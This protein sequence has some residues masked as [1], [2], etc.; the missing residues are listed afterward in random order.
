MG[1]GWRWSIRVLWK[2][3]SLASSGGGG[4]GTSAIRM[5]RAACSGGGGGG[6]SAAAMSPLSS[7]ERKSLMLFLLNSFK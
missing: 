2:G 4:G 1:M 7:V 6:D 5:H 3:V